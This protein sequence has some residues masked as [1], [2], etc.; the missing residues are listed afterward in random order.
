MKT[1]ITFGQIHTH[2][3][4]G[5]TLNKDCVGVIEAENE[6][7]AR[8]LAFEWFAGKFATTYREKFID[9]E[10]LNLFPRGII[11]LN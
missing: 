8:E 10:F 3:H 11:E 4:N 7:K 2:R 5:V 6:S 9:S 1:Y